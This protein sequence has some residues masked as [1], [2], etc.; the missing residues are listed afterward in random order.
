MND[1][2][3]HYLVQDLQRTVSRLANNEG[4]Y[5]LSWLGARIWQMPE[6]LVRL[7]EILFEV[8]PDWIVETG[9]KFGG[10]AIF[11]ASMLAL[12]GKKEGEG[13]VITCDIDILPRARQTFAEHAL[14]P[15]VRAVIEGSAADPAT[16]DQI[17][18]TINGEGRVLVFLDDNHNAD[19]VSAEMELYAPLVSDESY[20]IVADTIYGDLAGTPVG[21][22]SPKYPDVKNSNP[23][24]AVERFLA[25]RDDFVRDE[26]FYGKGFSN[27]PDG[28]LKRV[29]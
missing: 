28:F 24:V 5:E 22:P 26:R 11:F 10:S 17:R 18:E 27:F 19:H 14:G 4:W 6:D 20:L 8:K 12:A 1:K 3:T 16:V 15:R 9:T 13:G 23:R 25:E 29:R 21:E 7:Q 2:T